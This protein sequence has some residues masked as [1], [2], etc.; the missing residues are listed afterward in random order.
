MYFVSANWIIPSLIPNVDDFLNIISISVI[1]L[2]LFITLNMEC[3]YSRDQ[4]LLLRSSATSLDRSDCVRVPQFGLRR[5]GCRAGA[6][7]RLC[8]LAAHSV[9]SSVSCSRTPGGGEIPTIKGHRPA[10]VNKRQLIPV[11]REQSAVYKSECTVPK[12]MKHSVANYLV[13]QPIL[14]PPLSLFLSSIFSI[15][16]TCLEDS[17]TGLQLNDSDY[18]TA[19]ASAESA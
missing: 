13:T 17:C 14:G 7:C 10:Y 11:R 6:R 15:S 1:V 19:R 5:R 2:L 12:E 16:T 3:A 9:T 18:C 4:L 8:L